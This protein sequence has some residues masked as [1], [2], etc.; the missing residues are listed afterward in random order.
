[1]K[2]AACQKCV[3]TLHRLL[4]L[5]TTC[6]GATPPSENSSVKAPDLNHTTYPGSVELQSKLRIDFADLTVGNLIGKGSFKAVYRGR[7]NNVNVAVI[8]MRTG[9]MVTESRVMQRI[10]S[11]PNLVQ[12][13][14]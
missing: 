11:H 7:W 5:C 4:T 6:A 14:R 13:Y 8:C 12:F 9:G 2:A 10:S 1:M 3:R